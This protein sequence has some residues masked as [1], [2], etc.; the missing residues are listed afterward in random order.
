[1]N[2]YDVIVV[3]GG[4]AGIGAAL[5]LRHN[6]MRV[7]LFEKNQIG[8]RIRFARRV[9][10]LITDMPL[11]GIEVCNILQKIVERKSIDVRF[12][13]VIKIE[14]EGR[15]LRVLTDRGSFLSRY[16]VVATGLKPVVPKIKG[17]SDELIKD[18]LFF[19]WMELNRDR[20]SPVLIIGGGEVGAD[21]ACSLKEDGFDV[22]IFARSKSPDINPTLLREVKRLRIRL[23]TAVKYR[24]L[25]LSDSKIVLEYERGKRVFERS[26]KSILITCGG[27]P[28]IPKIDGKVDR[29]RL[30][31]CGDANASNAHQ[32][33]I[34]FGDG[35][36]TAMKITKIYRR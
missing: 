23:I 24:R 34:A 29:N 8:G 15:L 21:S 33:A 36:N 17:I 10:N 14:G 22:T 4:P 31:F 13:R 6:G 19:N 27:T 32:S 16:V 11:G 9:E 12:Q 5:Q 30:F 25:Y 7:L 3:G 20:D 2:I 26:A 18:R 1:M 35:V 28:D